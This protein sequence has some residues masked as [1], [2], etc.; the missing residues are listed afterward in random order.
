MEKN[1]NV[2]KATLQRYPIYLK[3]LRK[4]QDD[5]IQRIMSKDLASKVA[6][7]STTIRRDFSFLGNLGKQ[8]FGYDVA[9]LIQIFS[10][11]L[12]LGFDEKIILVGA[13]NL[14]K[15]LLN[16]N[17]WNN[18]VGEIV[19]A[20]DL[21]PSAVTGASVPVYNMSELKERLPEGCR[22]AILCISKNIQETVDLL[23]SYGITGIV[24]FTHEH[25][26]VPEN[27]VVKT[28]DV[29]SSI[30]ELVFETNSFKD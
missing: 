29:V 1:R 11:E 23:I 6:I 15:A 19:C 18:V 21:N 7:K 13:G 25:F 22:I 3:A 17:R 20:F 2:P 28:V 5:G 12:G 8:G 4:L 10:D 9:S 27:I 26:Q 16:Y 14:G 24:D 30:Q